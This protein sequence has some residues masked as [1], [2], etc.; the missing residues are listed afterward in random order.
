ME[1]VS[2][3]SLQRAEKVGAGRASQQHRVWKADTAEWTKRSGSLVPAN[4]SLEAAAASVDASASSRSHEHTSEKGESMLDMGPPKVVPE[5]AADRRSGGGNRQLSHAV[6]RATDTPGG[7]IS[8]QM[9]RVQTAAAPSPSHR[10]DRPPAAAEAKEPETE[11]MQ[12]DARKSTPAAKSNMAVA[13]TADAQ[14]QATAVAGSE[15]SRRVD[16]NSETAFMDSPSASDPDQNDQR[17]DSRSRVAQS[18][19]VSRDVQVLS[20]IH[21]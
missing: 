8:S 2:L 4:R 3:S 12:R 6:M 17:G 5:V 21:I 18:P 10:A 19:S 9:P 15:A 7:P 16:P 14:N 20:L 1:S 11:P 13:G